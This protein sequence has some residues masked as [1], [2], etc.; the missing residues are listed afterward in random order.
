MLFLSNDACD[1][2]DNKRRPR[3]QMPKREKKEN[4]REK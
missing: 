4:R 3:L 1:L 2:K